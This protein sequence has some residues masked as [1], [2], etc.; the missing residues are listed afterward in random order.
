MFWDKAAVDDDVRVLAA[1]WVRR[2]P[3]PA[4]KCAAVALQTLQLL[5]HVCCCCCLADTTESHTDT[6]RMP[7]Y[8]NNYQPIPHAL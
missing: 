2:R 7:K 5:S 4:A 6:E 1:R 3:S 8:N